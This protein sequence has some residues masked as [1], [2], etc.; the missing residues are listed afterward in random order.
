MKSQKKQRRTSRRSHSEIRLDQKQRGLLPDSQ[1]CAA[2]WASARA[3]TT[4]RLTA[5]RVFVPSV[6]IAFVW[7]SNNFIT[8]PIRFTAAKKSQNNQTLGYQSP[9]DF[10]AEHLLSPATQKGKSSVRQSWANEPIRHRD[11]VCGGIVD[12][13]GQSLTTTTQSKRVIGLWS[14]TDRRRIAQAIS[15]G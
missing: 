4:N 5:C 9:N 8:I 15:N 7:L 11:G 1:P 3:G 2:C 6:P 12:R 14:N 13:T 10:E